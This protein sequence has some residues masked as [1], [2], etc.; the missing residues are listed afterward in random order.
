MPESPTRAIIYVRISTVDTCMPACKSKK[1]V[2]PRVI[3]CSF[4]F[5]WQSVLK[6][7]CFW[8]LPLVLRKDWGNAYSYR[9]MN[10]LAA[11]HAF[12]SS[13][14][15]R[16]KPCIHYLTWGFGFSPRISRKISNQNLHLSHLDQV[17]E[18]IF[19]KGLSG[20]FT[21]TEISEVKDWWI[22]EN[23]KRKPWG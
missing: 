15:L 10:M 8:Y 22:K 5:G 11:L 17:M 3:P 9:I 13:L 1:T 19:G 12:W 6:S 16:H 18:F 4:L 7:F 21:T 23:L 14:I 20:N 2:G